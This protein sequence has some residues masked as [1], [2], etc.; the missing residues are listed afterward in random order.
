MLF[1]TL[2]VLAITLAGLSAGIFLAFS[3]GVMPGLRRADDG[4]FVASMRGIN[5]GVINPAFLVPIFVSPLLLAGVGIAALINA[6]AESESGAIGVLLI[7][8]AGIGL[9]GGVLVTGARNVPLN[10]ALDAST[11]DASTT[12]AAFERAWVASNHVRTVLT[13]VAFVIAVVAAVLR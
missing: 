4:S 5:R 7:V 1:D 3:G 2:L 13:L 9:L 12:R 6:T 10:N 11:A 8:A